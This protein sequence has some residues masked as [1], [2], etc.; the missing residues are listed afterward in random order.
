MLSG[1]RAKGL[2]LLLSPS[3]P[4]VSPGKYDDDD[5]DDTEGSVEEEGEEEEEEFGSEGSGIEETRFIR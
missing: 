3:L 1:R 2:S 4:P 5:D